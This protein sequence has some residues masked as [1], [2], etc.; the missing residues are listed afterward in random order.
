MNEYAFVNQTDKTAYISDASL[1]FKGTWSPAGTYS[2][3][4]EA[5]DYNNGKF[6]VLVQNY[7]TPPIGSLSWSELVAVGTLSSQDPVVIAQTALD[8][9]NIATA[10]AISSSNLAEQALAAQQGA[11]FTGYIQTINGNSVVYVSVNYANGLAVSIDPYDNILLFSS[12]SS[13]KTILNPSGNVSA[14]AGSWSSCIG[15]NLMNMTGFSTG[16]SSSA[17]A[18]TYLEL[19]DV[20]S[21]TTLGCTNA[22]LSALNLSGLDSLTSLNLQNNLLTTLDVS[23]F[24]QLVVLQC[25]GNSLTSISVSGL[26]LLTTVDANNNLL[27]SLDVSV[28]SSLVTCYCSSNALTS[29]DFSSNPGIVTIDCSQNNLTSLILTNC[30]ALNSVHCGNNALTGLILPPALLI[31][32]VDCSNNALT[33]EAVDGILLELVT[34]GWTGGSVNLSGGTNAAPSAPTGQSYVTALTNNG[35]N[36][37]TN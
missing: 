3:P 22:S 33:Q 19:K 20:S 21:L 25:G 23:A 12:A 10:I 6:I 2:P 30:T 7:N 29:L 17:I 37:V 5:V 13:L 34:S 28:L 9:A 4:I 1:A 16:F 31:D 27:T 26:T 35:W 18:L 24:S 32:D 11:T 36:V 8:Q 15:H 14:L